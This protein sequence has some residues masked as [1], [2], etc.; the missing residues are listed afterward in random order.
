ME[1]SISIWITIHAIQ[2]KSLGEILNK[3]TSCVIYVLNMLLNSRLKLNGVNNI[4]KRVKENKTRQNF[5]HCE[6]ILQNWV[7]NKA[8]LF[9]KKKKKNLSHHKNC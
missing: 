1:S 3:E 9:W 6:T 7:P 2:E 5:M 8:M 4:F